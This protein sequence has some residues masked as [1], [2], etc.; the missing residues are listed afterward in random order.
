MGA[1]GRNLLKLISGSAVGAS[2]GALLARGTE[3]AAKRGDPMARVAA[4]SSSDTKQGK[5]TELRNSIR[6]RWQR[7]QEEGDQAKEAREAELRAYFREKVDDPTAFPP[8]A[9]TR[10]D[11]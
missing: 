9:P 3:A 7:A 6:D 11:R 8:G 5:I 1:T 2:V 10:T 4:G